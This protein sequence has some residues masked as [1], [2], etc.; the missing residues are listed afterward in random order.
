VR[1]QLTGEAHGVTVR[2]DNILD[3][4]RIAASHRRHHGHPGATTGRQDIGIPLTQS[5]QREGQAPE[6]IAHVGINTGQVPDHLGLKVC[7]NGWE[8]RL[9][10]S[11]IGRIIR[12][13]R[14]LEIEAA[15]GFAEGIV[16]LTV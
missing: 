8:V 4:R 5:L 1:C 9:Q 13:I 16:F 14:E 6:F 7:K 10:G 11:E 15:L 2:L 12:A 3:L